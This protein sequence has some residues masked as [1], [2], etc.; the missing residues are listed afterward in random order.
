MQL[1]IEYWPAGGDKIKDG[2]GSALRAIIDKKVMPTLEPLLEN[3]KLDPELRVAIQEHLLVLLNRKDK[4]Q[5]GR[6]LPG[7]PFVDPMS[8]SPSVERDVVIMD[9]A[10][11][12]P[13]AVTPS[14]T[15]P[16]NAF[17]GQPNSNKMNHDNNSE[18]SSILTLNQAPAED[19][20]FSPDD[21]EEEEEEEDNDDDDEEEEEE[22]DEEVDMKEGNNLSPST[23]E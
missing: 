22:E 2:I 21:E 23:G 15:P 5:Q 4:N 6:L 10:S 12:T 11:P 9:V 3:P 17:G 14:S 8:F 19:V 13:L 18:S 1:S 7:P 20:D 16:V